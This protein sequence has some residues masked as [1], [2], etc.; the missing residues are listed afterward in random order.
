M[1]WDDERETCLFKTFIFDIHRIAKA[2]EDIE[3]EGR[4]R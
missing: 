1:F 2:L 3:A 4:L